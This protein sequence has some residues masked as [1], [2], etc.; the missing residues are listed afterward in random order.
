MVENRESTGVNWIDGMGPTH[1]KKKRRRL[2]A[3]G[4]QLDMRNPDSSRGCLLLNRGACRDPK[5]LRGYQR[6]RI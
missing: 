4:E 3:P 1:P 6:R 5:N 2:Q